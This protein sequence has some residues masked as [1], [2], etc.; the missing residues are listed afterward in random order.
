MSI[1]SILE[2]Y[3]GVDAGGNGTGQNLIRTATRVFTAVSSDPTD[4]GLWT[5]PVTDG[6][7]IIPVR[8][9]P[10]PDNGYYVSGE[11]VVT[12]KGPGY[13]EVK[14]P[15]QT[16]DQRDPTRHEVNPLSLPAQL[17]W[18]DAEREVAYDED[19]QDLDGFGELVVNSMNE[20]F[21]PPLTRHISDPVLTIVRNQAAFSAADKLLYQDT[22]CEEV[23]WGAAV[24]RARLARISA[25]NVLA[26]TPYWSVTYEI[27]FRMKTPSGT[28]AAHAWWHQVLD[29]GVKYKDAGGKTHYMPAGELCLLKADGTRTTP[30]SPHWLYFQEYFNESWA[31]LGFE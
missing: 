25:R 22:I 13:F 5:F 6:T 14:V 19:L 17:S 1:T 20:P 29:Q 31:A 23:F 12:T 26:E 2:G 3:T 21:N 30:D 9:T 28:T 4:K 15:Y 18:S 11:P 24:G 7:I 8:G 10:H 27:H 16:P